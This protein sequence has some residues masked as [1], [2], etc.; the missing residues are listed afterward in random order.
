[1]Q[2]DREGYSAHFKASASGRWTR[3][4]ERK[5]SV[6]PVT[7]FH[8]GPGVLVSVASRSKVSFLAF[9]AANVFID[10]ESLY[11]MIT[12][13]PRI[14]T[15]LHTYMGSTLAAAVVV[16]VFLPCRWLA[17]KL[18]ASPLLKWRGLDVTAV[19]L[20]SL[21]GAWSHVLFDSVMHS[22]ITPLAPF[23]NANGLYR[24][25]PL[26]TLHLFCIG[27][28]IVGVMWYALRSNNPLQRP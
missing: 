12:A 20:G 24:I 14:H 15:F 27:A 9:V 8:F 23:S 21:V 6:V 17:L 26:G 2:A 4:L 19:V 10:V 7:P 11:N 18:P 5:R 25:V 28:G 16:V 3:A 1:L 22:D 13:Q